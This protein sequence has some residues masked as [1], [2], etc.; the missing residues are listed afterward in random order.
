[1][2]GQWAK[3]SSNETLN[4]INYYKLWLEK[5]DILEKLVMKYELNNVNYGYYLELQGK[6]II[7]I[8]G[9]DS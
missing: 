8:R 4:L 2:K 1:M 6:W 5:N 7:T 3:E 9:I